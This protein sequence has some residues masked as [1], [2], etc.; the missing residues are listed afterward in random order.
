M[1]NERQQLIQSILDYSNGIFRKL[2]MSVP[3]E[4]LTSELTVAQ[5]RVLL[6]LHTE[7]A[8][9]MST[10]AQASAVA[11]STTTGIVDNLVK[12]GFVIRE[13]DAHDRRLVV[14][15]L[16]P[17]G[18]ALT[19]KIWTLAQAQMKRLLEGLDMDQLRQTTAVAEILYKNV[20]PETS[21]E[22]IT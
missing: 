15:L 14:C 1:E 9:K 6:L 13:T 3:E 10:I 21:L 22:D 12:K 2:H 8:S 19:N 4:W 5:L 11:L 7:G 17:Q 16:S 20:V 18:Q